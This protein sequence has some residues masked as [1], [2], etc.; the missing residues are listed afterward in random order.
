MSVSNFESKLLDILVK[1]SRESHSSIAK[2][3]NSSRQTI[4]YTIDSLVNK[5]IIDQFY[6]VLD[7]SKIGYSNYRIMLTFTKM[8]TINKDKIISYLSKIDS[9]LWIAECGNK[10]NLIINYLYKDNLEL[11]NFIYNF[12]NKF[13]HFVKDIDFLLFIEAQEI[14]TKKL[15]LFGSSKKDV[16]N[17]DSIDYSIL[18]ILSKNSREKSINIAQKLNITPNT[19]ISRIKKL[20]SLKIILNYTLLI[21]LEK[22]KEH[23]YKFLINF[24]NLDKKNEEKLFF[25]LKNCKDV[26]GVLKFVGKWDLEVE[27]KSKDFNYILSVSNDLKNNFKDIVSHFE[28]LPIYKE[29]RYSFI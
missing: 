16:I 26:I 4:S 1:N 11:Y 29:H 19:V 10:W 13:Y 27:I 20:E 24:Y 9:V 5:G 14:Y 28:I 18:K 22:I 8:D 15:Y 25:Y 3:L 7:F 17:L 2:K 12:K 21:N 23:K 6:T